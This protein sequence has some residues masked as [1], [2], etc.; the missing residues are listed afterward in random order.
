MPRF[1]LL[2]AM[3]KTSCVLSL[4]FL[5]CM[6]E[7][8]VCIRPWIDGPVC[9]LQK[10][11]APTAPSPTPS[12]LDYARG[13]GLSG[14]VEGTVVAKTR[15]REEACGCGAQM[16]R[17]AGEERGLR[18]CLGSAPAEAWKLTLRMQRPESWKSSRK[19]SLTGSELESVMDLTVFSPGLLAHSFPGGWLPTCA[20]CLLASL[21]R[22]LQ[23]FVSREK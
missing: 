22:S 18:P 6:N 9:G 7:Y 10:K 23:R 1:P 12:I 21:G 16:W 13:S 17:L 4:S 3:V 5:I 15:G 11:T 14:P 19:S 2:H 20:G 8:N